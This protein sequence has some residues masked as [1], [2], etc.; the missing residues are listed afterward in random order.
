MRNQ[1]ML[2]AILNQDVP[3]TQSV[4]ESAR[5]ELAALVAVAEAADVIE[6]RG[7]GRPPTIAQMLALSDALANL[8]AVRN[9]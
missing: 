5:K 7:C 4:L 9:Q 1:S 3:M 2:V 8:A 6:R